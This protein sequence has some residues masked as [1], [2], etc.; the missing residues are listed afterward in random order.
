MRDAPV[1][2]AGG[3]PMF[4]VLWAISG[5]SVAA[6]APE[7]VEGKSVRWLKRMLAKQILLC[8]GCTAISDG[9]FKV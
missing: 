1:P 5:R 7:Q 2:C 3:Q 6:F 9:Y 4:R 8:N